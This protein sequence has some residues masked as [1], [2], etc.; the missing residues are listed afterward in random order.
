MLSIGRVPRY[1]NPM[2][3]QD[4]YHKEVTAGTLHAD[5]AQIAVLPELERLRAALGEPVKRGFFR[6]APEPI[7]GLYMWG[8]VGRGKS[9]LMDMLYE[10]VVAAKERWHFHAFMQEIQAGL[11]KARQSGVDDAIKPVAEAV[12]SDIR[13]LAFDEMQ[14]TDIADHHL[15]VRVFEEDGD[16]ED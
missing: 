11:H 1:P 7:R 13:L 14:I 4:A 12:A 16:D 10:E 5:D 3:V 2:T 8:G 9:M 15:H 6:K